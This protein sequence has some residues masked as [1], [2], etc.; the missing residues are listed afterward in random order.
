MFSFSIS[1][2]FIFPSF[3]NPQ[4]AF[5]FTILMQNRALKPK[6]QLSH[7]YQHSMKAFSSIFNGKW[8][9]T[10]MKKRN[11]WK[12]SLKKREKETNKGCWFSI[13]YA[14]IRADMSFWMYVKISSER[15]CWM[16]V[17][18]DSLCISAYF[19]LLVCKEFEHL[20]LVNFLS[21]RKSITEDLFW[22]TS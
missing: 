14:S 16:S 7:D 18:R 15:R 19:V 1:L 6:A 20:F 21:V 10:K 5:F 9:R 13:F 8:K 2:F 4:K 3:R 17:C 22:A 11:C 12:K